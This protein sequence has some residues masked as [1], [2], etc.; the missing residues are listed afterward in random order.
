MHMSEPEQRERSQHGGA[1]MAPHGRVFD[2]VGDGLVLVDSDGEIIDMNAAAEALFGI[3]RGETI[4]RNVAVLVPDLGASLPIRRLFEHSRTQGGLGA[5]VSSNHSVIPVHI[6]V[7]EAPNGGTQSY[8]LAVRDFRTIRSEQRRVVEA[9]RLAAVDE[10]MHALA[11]ESRNALQRMQSCLTLIHLRG[12]DEVQDLVDDMQKAQDE[13]K[14]LYEAVGNFAAPLQLQIR[15]TD[16]RKLLD[17]TWHQLS[18]R[19]AAKQ[20]VWS[21]SYRE[22][23]DT[24]LPVD[25]GRLGEVFENVLVNAVEASPE[26]GCIIAMLAADDTSDEPRVR[27]TIEDEGEGIDET[28]RERAFDLLYSTKR[29]GTGMGLAVARRVLREHGGDIFIEPGEDGGTRVAMTLPRKAKID[30]DA[31]R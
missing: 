6:L 19:W 28:A 2:F 17:K 13:L 4:G 16:V 14:C 12:G 26:H 8:V 3:E 20:L 22:D 7:S 9:E 27:I 5:E 23:L 1:G 25:A 24:R 30:G 15:R 18:A 31:R 21:T 29:G 11:H 10:T